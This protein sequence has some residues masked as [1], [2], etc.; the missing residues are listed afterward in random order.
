MPLDGFPL[1]SRALTKGVIN[2][3]AFAPIGMLINGFFSNEIEAGEGTTYFGYNKNVRHQR[4]QQLQ[5]Q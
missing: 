2:K 4:S 3:E 1:M 5:T